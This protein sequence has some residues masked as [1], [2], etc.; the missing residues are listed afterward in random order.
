MPSALKTNLSKITLAALAVSLSAPAWALTQDEITNYRKPDHYAVMEEGAKKEGAVVWYCTMRED[1]GC[2]PYSAAFE[3]KYPAIKVTY[4]ASA[5]EAIL[6]KSL[7]ESRANSVRADVMMASVADSLKGTGIPQKFWSPEFA[8]F[9]PQVIDPEGYWVS[10]R[11]TWNGLVWN[12]KL[13]SKADE[14]TSWEDLI[15]PKY[16]NK[17]FWASGSASG[18]PRM[19]THF[20]AMWGDDKA[21]AFLK[22]L[23][24]QNIRTAPGDSGAV[25]AGITSGE[26]PLMV[27]HPIQQIVTD[28]AKG[29]PVDGVNPDNALARVS[30]MAMLRGAP[31]PY[32]AMLFVD[33]VLSVDGQKMVAVVGYSPTRAGVEPL[34]E[35]RAIQPNM[36]GKKEII[37]STEK[38]NEMNAKSQD[39][40]QEMFR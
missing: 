9:D 30:G 11:T 1:V 24:G 2:R 22:Q 31:H 23:Q 16:K 25:M 17:I 28:K 26:F 34:P 12:T 38:E 27:G 10:W 32:A 14:P 19:I 29:A 21:M 20:R 13:I 3:K 33:F 37:L 35:Y 7:A 39:W 6:Q 8:N 4:I 15:N 18:A 5:I 40:Y 36:N